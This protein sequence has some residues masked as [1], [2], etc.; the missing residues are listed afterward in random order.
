MY[1][2]V[3]DILNAEFALKQGDD[4][5]VICTITGADGSTLIKPPVKKLELLLAAQSLI[6]N[7]TNEIEAK[8]K[9]LAAAKAAYT[10]ISEL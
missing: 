7:L 9:D 8:Q 4:T 10:T 1:Y 3:T 5:M 6:N 2:N